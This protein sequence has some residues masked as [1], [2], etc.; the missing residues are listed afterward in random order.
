MARRAITAARTSG[1][2]PE[3]QVRVS[4]D[5]RNFSIEFHVFSLSGQVQDFATS[6]SFWL[7]NSLIPSSDNSRP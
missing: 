1:H 6:T 7:T 3:Y 4:G 2:L 5:D